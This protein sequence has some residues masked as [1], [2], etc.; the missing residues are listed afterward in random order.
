MLAELLMLK[1][2]VTHYKIVLLLLLLLLLLETWKNMEEN[3][4]HWRFD[5]YISYFITRWY[6]I[7]PVQ[8]I[9]NKGDPLRT[10]GSGPMLGRRQP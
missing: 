8:L 4:E 5:K 1:S 2:N 9:R 10:Y 7:V 3:V 6:A